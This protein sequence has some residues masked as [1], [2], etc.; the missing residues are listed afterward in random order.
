M[1]VPMGVVGLGD[2]FLNV[3]GGIVDENVELAALER[4]GDD[5]G[6]T[7]GVREVGGGAMKRSLPPRRSI[8]ASV[9]ASVRSLRKTN[10]PA[11]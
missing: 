4:G 11:P 9:W 3:D 1:R 7:L 5:A 2:R 10:A 6:R 8:T